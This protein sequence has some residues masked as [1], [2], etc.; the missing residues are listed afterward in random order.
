MEPRATNSLLTPRRAAI[1]AAVLL[2]FLAA[3]CSNET[4]TE[5]RPTEAE[6][7]EAYFDTPLIY[8]DAARRVRR[9]I[10]GAEL[11]KELTAPAEIELV[12]HSGLPC[13]VYP[14]NGTEARDSYGSPVAAEVWFCF[15]ADGRLAHKRWF[16]ASA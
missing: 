5:R 4:Q 15:D 6:T 7:R 14:L 10:T 9:G 3:G 12:D 16:P 2:A 8:R 11:T 13:R 1:P